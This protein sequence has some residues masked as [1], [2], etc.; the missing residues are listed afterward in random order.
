MPIKLPKFRYL[1][2]V[3]VIIAIIM[4]V[5]DGTIMNVALPSLAKE[6]RI[7]PEMSIW[8][9][10]AY[11]MTI[12]MFL[13]IFAAVGDLFGYRKVF[14]YGVATFTLASICCT[15]SSGFPMLIASRV[16]Q[17]LGAAAVMSVNTALVRLIYPPET[18]GRGMSAN[19]VAVAVSA[20]AGPT[21]AGVV[22]ASLSWH[23]LF[24]INIPLGLAAFFIGI[25]LL[26]ERKHGER[27]KIS[28]WNCAGN[29]L[30]FGLLI[31]SL[32]SVAHHGDRTWSGLAFALF[33]IVGFFYLRRQL[34]DDFPMLPVDLLKIPIFS[35]SIVSSVCS[36]MAQMLALVALPF[37]LQDA[38]DFS[39][40]EIG[41]LITPWPIATMVTAPIA[42]RLVERVHPGTLGAVGMALFATGL[43]A[44]YLMPPDTGS[45]DIWW[46]IMLCGA[47][48]GLF[49]TPNN[50][51]IVSSAPL[52]RSGGA[53]GMLGMARLVGQ[54]VGT[55]AVAIV[56]G[57]MPHTVGS[58]SCLL[59][60]A[61]AAL[62]SGVS[63]ISRLTQSFSAP[64]K[65]T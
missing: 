1:P 64:R 23:W 38:L 4:S 42:G 62:L 16:L 9:V 5:L 40:V 41:L 3:A 6:F 53:S 22:L 2:V 52:H 13:L 63:S 14:L 59:I 44:L 65:K 25:K 33:L 12:M 60:A 57:I 20:A 31:Y 29:A 54:T 7:G 11:Q 49:Q 43:I 28:L 45:M 47:G 15:L 18:L 27:K 26:P 24:A 58:R 61:C 50:L 46:R 34:R 36:F 19:A 17:G 51:T 56:F 35:L 55:T 37:L 30:T 39:P 32:E 21:L 8:I 10:N 48:F